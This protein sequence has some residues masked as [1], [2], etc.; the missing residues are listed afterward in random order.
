MG[1]YNGP[2]PKRHQ[3]LGNSKMLALFDRG[4]LPKAMREELAERA[5]DRKLA[6]RYKDKDGKSCWSGTKFL[7]SS[8]NLGVKRILCMSILFI[9]PS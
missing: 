4:V 7:K 1:H 2:T 9:L 5:G 3:L 8:Q 6:K